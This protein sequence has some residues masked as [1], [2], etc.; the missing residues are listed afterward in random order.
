MELISTLSTVQKYFSNTMSVIEISI[1]IF[2]LRYFAFHGVGATTEA[3]PPT[4]QADIQA[5]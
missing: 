5:P 3:N 2:R 1:S 4:V